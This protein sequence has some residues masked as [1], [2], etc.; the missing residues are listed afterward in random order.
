MD[1]TETQKLLHQNGASGDLFGGGISISGDYAIIASAYDDNEKGVD[2]GAAHIFH[3]IGSEWVLE[4]DLVGLDIVGGNHFGVSV[5][6]DGNYAI[7]GA[8]LQDSWRGSAYVFTVP[9]PATLSLLILG[10]LTML[11]RRS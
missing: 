3:L 1:M 11:R 4:K 8:D 2:A 7:V 9:E 10:G 5:G 6:I